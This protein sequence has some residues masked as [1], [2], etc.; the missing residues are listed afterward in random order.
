M[1]SLKKYMARGKSRRRR[2]PLSNTVLVFGSIV[3]G[4]LVYLG[5]LA[6]PGLLPRS[7]EQR[8]L[9]D[10]D[11]IQLAVFGHRTAYP[12]KPLAGGGYG[13]RAGIVGLGGADRG[14]TFA[15]NPTFA[16]YHRGTSANLKLEDVG[17]DEITTLGAFNTNPAGGERGGTPLWEDV[18]G[19]GRRAFGAEELFYEDAS[20]P[21]SVDHWN[22]TTVVEFVPR[23]QVEVSDTDVTEYVVDSRDWFIDFVA[24]IEKDYLDKLPASASLDNHPE[25]EGSYSW[26]IDEDGSL[27]SLRYEAPTPDSTGY[28]GVYP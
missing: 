13:R 11:R 20:P 12:G 16:Q 2:I 7:V 15:L 9:D 26:Y 5:W 28:L 21:P 3:L 8:Y 18:D 1:S 24:L 22:T 19:D 10:H 23:S 27:K 17:S 4:F 6:L 14:E 25:G